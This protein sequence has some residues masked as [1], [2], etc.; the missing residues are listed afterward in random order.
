MKI[1]SIVGWSQS[2][3]T[4]LIVELIKEFKKRGE[5]I[6]A[7]KKI[8]HK[9]HLEPESKDSFLF[10]SA[11]AD[12]VFLVAKNEMMRINQINSEAEI[13]DKVLENADSYDM[14]LLEGL[15]RENIPIIEVFDSST[16][17]KQKLPNESLAAMVSMQK[18]SRPFPVFQPDEI[19]KII[20][21]ILNYK[22]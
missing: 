1:F 9:Y 8:G 15:N 3:K 20:D 12:E 7:L 18:I 22:Q 11:G 16:Q 6:L 14:I 19:N 5:K 13:F 2:G 10:L 21:F 17:E 4:T